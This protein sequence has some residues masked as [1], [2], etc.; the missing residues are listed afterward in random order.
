MGGP[1]TGYEAATDT[2]HTTGTRNMHM[3]MQLWQAQQLYQ[4]PR[5]V[6]L[7]TSYTNSEV[8]SKLESPQTA[9]C[10]LTRGGT[11]LPEKEYHEPL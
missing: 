10:M 8:V 1:A 4:L 6:W 2:C 11:L 3:G 5:E 9:T 7:A